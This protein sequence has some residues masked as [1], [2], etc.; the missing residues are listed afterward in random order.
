MTIEV[1]D[2]PKTEGYVDVAILDGGGMIGNSKIMH[3]DE[4]ERDVPMSCWVFYIHHPKSG[5]KIVWDVGISAVSP[6]FRNCTDSKSKEDYGE[7][8]QIVFYGPARAFGPKEDLATQIA[9]R[10]GVK[11]SEIDAVLF[12]HAHWYLNLR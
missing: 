5:K 3:A 10:R 1:L 7:A 9:K 2:F 12:S 8:S 4:P 6:H 11:G